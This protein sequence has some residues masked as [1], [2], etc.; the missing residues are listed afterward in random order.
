MY[1]L[2]DFLVEF[3][4]GFGMWKRKKN[5]IYV[6]GLRALSLDGIGLEGY[7]MCMRGRWDGWLGGP[8]GYGM[9]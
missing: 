7:R 1:V 5:G 2:F 6:V 8:L 9:L 3:G 4:G